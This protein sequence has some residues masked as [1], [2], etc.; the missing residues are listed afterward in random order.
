M[1]PRA[2][3]R[4]MDTINLAGIP[5]RASSGLGGGFELMRGDE[6]VNALAKVKSFIPAE[7]AGDIELNSS[8]IT[9]DLSPWIGNRNLQPHL[10]LIKTAL[11]ESKVLSFEY[12]DLRG[13]KTARTAEAQ[14]L[15]WNSVIGIG[16][17][18]AASGAV[19]ACSSCPAPP[20]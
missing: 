19:F 10:D 12:A 4:D 6:V 15:V 13:N 8:Q 18:I 5:V 20:T 1:S 3:Y 17:A 9:I 7:S 11:R 14:R 16:T 2:I